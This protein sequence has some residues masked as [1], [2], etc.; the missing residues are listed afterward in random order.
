M[1][2]GMD[3]L[4][5]VMRGR[6]VVLLTATDSEAEPVRLALKNLERYL[7]A[8]KTVYTGEVGP[9]AATGAGN[10]GGAGLREV[11]V[12]LAVTGCD[13]ANVAHTLTCLLGVMAPAPRLVV[14]TGI[15]GAFPRLATR[16]P[17]G[18]GDI[19]LATRETYS[20]TGSSSPGGWLS[21]ADLNLPIACID[22]RETGGD[23]A[24]DENLVSAAFAVL[25]GVEWGAGAAAAR[26]AILRGPCLTSSRV[27][28]LDCEAEAAAVRWGALAESME[29]AAAAHICALFGVPFLEIRGISNLVGDRDRECWQVERAVAVAGRAALAV[30]AA[31]DAL[32]LEEVSSLE[33]SR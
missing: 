4:R 19:V 20:D 25:E 7:V 1:Q 10:A 27:T 30:V 6:Q 13:K 5:E 33:E 21:A 2:P 3:M 32:P 22:D 14:Q 23:F 18:I 9:A 15:A 28:G 8:T 29:G 31:L 12:A 24:L 11:P 16:R 17:A 26:P